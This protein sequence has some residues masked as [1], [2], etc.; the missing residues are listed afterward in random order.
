[1]S[2]ELCLAV[3]KQ[4][5]KKIKE[6]YKKVYK[7]DKSKIIDHIIDLT[8]YDRKYCIHQLNKDEIKLGR[9]KRVVNN[10][11]YTNYL[12]DQLVKTWYAS[13]KICS[14]RLAP[15]LSEIVDVLERTNHIKLT[16]EQRFLLKKLSPSTIDRL[17]RRCNLIN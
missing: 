9:K 5:L 11:K 13:N 6:K 1:M 15:F 12:K 4:L 17:L 2:T 16:D 10:L 14:K 7:K 8:G 3:K